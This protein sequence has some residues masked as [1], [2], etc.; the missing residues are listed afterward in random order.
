MV[1]VPGQSDARKR[2]PYRGERRHGAREESQQRLEIGILLVRSGKQRSSSRAL[3]GRETYCLR[4]YTLI[5]VEFAVEC[6]RQHSFRDMDIAILSNFA[7]F[8]IA[9]VRIA[10]SV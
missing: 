10:A 8:V 2:E 7:A 6:N 5:P 1:V 4:R 3:V 9:D